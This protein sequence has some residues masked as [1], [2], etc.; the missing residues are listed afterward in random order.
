MEQAVRYESIIIANTTV[1]LE[2][3]RKVLIS[4]M[5]RQKRV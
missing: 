3:V 2:F 5:L 4:L 1:A